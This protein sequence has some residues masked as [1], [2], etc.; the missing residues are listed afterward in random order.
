M[1]K[2]TKDTKKCVIKRKLEFETH[3]NCLKATHVE[4]K[5]NHLH[6]NIIDINSFTEL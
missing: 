2:N 3:K 1:W 6:K 5:I 4:N